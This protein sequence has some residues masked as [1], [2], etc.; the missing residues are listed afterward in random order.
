MRRSDVLLIFFEVKY[1]QKLENSFVKITGEPNKPFN[2]DVAFF[3]EKGL[4]LDGKSNHS[5]ARVVCNSWEPIGDEKMQCN[6][7]INSTNVS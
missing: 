6:S 5:S 2:E 3:T 1:I 4:L 7:Q